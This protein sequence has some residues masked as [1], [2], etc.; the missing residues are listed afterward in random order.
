MLSF[1]LQI[2]EDFLDIWPVSGV[3]ARD[4]GSQERFLAYGAD[5]LV[6]YNEKEDRQIYR[7]KE[8]CPK[9]KSMDT[10][11]V[12][13]GKNHSF[14]CLDCNYAEGIGTDQPG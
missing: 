4:V 6:V 14:Y 2:G 7:G 9:C 8:R 1:N 13:E 12:G 11:T 3:P 10:L 5:P